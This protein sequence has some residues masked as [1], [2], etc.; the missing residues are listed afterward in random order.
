MLSRDEPPV[1]L[2]PVAVSGRLL[3]IDGD[4]MRLSTDE[5]SAFLRSTLKVTDDETIGQLCAYAGGWVGG[6]Q[7]AVAAG[8]S[9]HGAPILLKDSLSL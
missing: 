8:S 3:L 5:S 6:L 4:Q 7:L 1:Y 9:R 2:G